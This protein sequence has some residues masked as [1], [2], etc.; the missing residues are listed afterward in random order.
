MLNFSLKRLKESHQGSWIALDFFML[1]LL[2]LN[3]ALILFDSLYATD[4]IRQSLNQLTP[5]LL[6]W[7]KPIHANFILIDL[8]FV[9]IFLT[10]FILRWF[11]AVKNKDYLR[12]YFYPFIHWY[13]LVGCIPVG[14]ARF[15]RFLRVFSIIYRLQKYKI[16][17]IRQSAPY[18][19]IAFYYDVFVEELSD[20]IVAK[21]LSDAQDDL[22]QGSPLLEEITTEVLAARKPI[23]CNWVA[24][25]AVHS[26]HSIEDMQAGS[27]LREH[28]RQS[29]GR[30]VRNNSQ[31][32]ALKLVPVVG[33]GIEKMLENAVTDIVIQSVI[34]LLT[35]VTPE[36]ID[37]LISHSIA[38][39]SE[40]DKLDQEMLNVVD[41]CIEL[42]KGHVSHQRWKTRL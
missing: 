22:R 16:I 24:S 15:L 33:S 38:S 3:L 18:R 27:T 7:Y 35:D 39:S 28:V 8:V 23:V 37:R 10:E 20:R 12:W 29:V 41:E 9:A 4:L 25:L 19:F 2:I 1:G 13:D 30:A 5:A 42:L 32:S 17:D 36:K 11:V 6:E 40:E 34:N 14:G 21:V 26:G 31:V